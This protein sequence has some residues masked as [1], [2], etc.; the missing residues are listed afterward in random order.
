MRC[1]TAALVLC[2]FAALFQPNASTAAPMDLDTIIVDETPE[3]LCD[4]LAYDPFA[5]F[6][7]VEWAQPFHT[8]DFYRARPACAQAMKKHPDEPRFALGTALA[9][10]A[11]KRNGRREAACASRR[12]NNTS[13]ILA[14]AYISP[15]AKPPI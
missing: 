4:R 14:L 2:G 15:E 6:G 7:P 5:G 8:I 13:A 10:I 11:G 12:Q 1:V 9:S 3:Q